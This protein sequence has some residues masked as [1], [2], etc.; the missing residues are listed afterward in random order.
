[1]VGVQFC[2][3]RTMLSR[4]LKMCESQVRVV[5]DSFVVAGFVVFCSW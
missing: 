5:R 1:M 2:G 3:F 4:V